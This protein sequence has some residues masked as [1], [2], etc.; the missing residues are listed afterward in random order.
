M[1]ATKDKSLLDRK[2]L[3]S[4][5]GELEQLLK[6]TVNDFDLAQS[7]VTDLTQQVL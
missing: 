2:E 4:R 6:E 3:I 1:L 5:V 7:H